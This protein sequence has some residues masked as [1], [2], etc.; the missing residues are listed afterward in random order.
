MAP[1]TVTNMAEHQYAVPQVPG[2]PA[3][4]KRKLRVVGIGAGF[5]N[6][7]L[8]YKHKTLL[9]NEFLDLTIYEKNPE[10]G[11]TWVRRLQGYP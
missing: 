8:A 2:Q 1:V 7:T 9:N 3:F 4:A 10:I 11:G 6:L 5:A